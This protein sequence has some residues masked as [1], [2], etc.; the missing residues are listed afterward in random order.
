MGPCGWVS[1]VIDARSTVLHKRGALGTVGVLC[2]A[3][4]SRTGLV[5]CRKDGWSAVIVALV[6]VA[7]CNQA[8][9]PMMAGDS[10]DG[11]T[12]GAATDGPWEPGEGELGSLFPLV[13]GATWTYRA[14]NGSGQVLGTEIVEASAVTH[15]GGPAFV[16]TDN[17]NAD[18]EWTESIIARSGTAALRVHKELMTAAG[19][20]EVVDYAPGFMRADDAWTAVGGLGELTYERSETD[21]QGSAPDV[22]MRGHAFSVLAVGESVT[23]PAGTFDCVAIERVRTTGASAGERV[24]F[25]YAPGVGKVKEE[26]PADDR[27]EELVSVSIPAGAEFP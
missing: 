14:I 23:T 10:E 1:D 24:L 3:G 18:G 15:D 13:D 26:R 27:F 17:A 5:V 6:A 22:E 12:E 9:P 16:F 8:D 11:T 21:G 2:H 25:W 4:F 20:Y 19:P 7:A